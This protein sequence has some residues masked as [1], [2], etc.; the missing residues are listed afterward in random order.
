[1]IHR[2]TKTGIRALAAAASAV[3]AFAAASGPSDEVLTVRAGLEK[4]RAVLVDHFPDIQ[5]RGGSP[6]ELLARLDADLYAVAQ[7]H[8][9]AVPGEWE[10][11]SLAAQLDE[12]LVEQL[13]SATYLQA[14]D[15]RGAA[16]LLVRAST[17]KTL[18]PLA[19]YVPRSYDPKRKA[20][21]VLMLHGQGQT[22][23]ELLATPFLRALADQSGAI[24][25]APFARGDR[26]FDG[27]ASSDTYDALAVLEGAFSFDLRRVYL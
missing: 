9:S 26:G 2:N 3:L 18:Q 8:S 19:V 5:S 22:E 13:V 15:V 27:P 20:P 4:T 11:L 25:A 16:A 14:S 23:N 6:G 24:F 10:A 17:D 7:P 1:V 12:S 21:L